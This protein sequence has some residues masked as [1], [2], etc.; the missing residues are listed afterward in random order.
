[1]VFLDTYGDVIP[2]YNVTYD[3][4]D[5]SHWWD[6]V[7]VNTVHAGNVI[8]TNSTATGNITGG[9]T[10]G[11]IPQWTGVSTLGNS[12]ITHLGGDLDFDAHNITNVGIVDGVD[13]SAHASRHKFLAT[14]VLN[15]KDL[16]MTTGK[17]IFL[18]S[19]LY[20]WAAVSWVTGSGVVNGGN[21]FVPMETGVTNGSTA[22]VQGQTWNWIDYT[23]GGNFLF[24]YFAVMQMGND[25]A[26]TDQMEMWCG[27]IDYTHGVQHPLV[28]DSHVAFYWKSTVDGT[29]AHL[30]ASNASG[31]V[32]TVTDTGVVASSNKE[33]YVYIKY[34]ASDIKYYVSEDGGVTYTLVATHTTN[35]PFGLGMIDFGAVKNSEAVNKTYYL[36]TV[37][38][39]L[40][41]E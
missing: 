29:P 36:G 13:V 4:G 37:K 34:M 24:R 16:Y 1:M 30:Y 14:D 9:G 28:T 7:Y 22:G 3:L 26:G 10:T 6:N 38:L 17:G 23:I 5:N 31:G 18:Q 8:S 2:T 39:L 12:P 35:R 20:L 33:I 11:T 41:D 15:I 19:I 32:Q 27:L 25:A 21:L 40:G